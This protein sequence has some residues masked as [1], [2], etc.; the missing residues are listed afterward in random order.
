MLR[1]VPNHFACSSLLACAHSDCRV[2]SERNIFARWNDFQ[3]A[4][5]RASASSVQLTPARAVCNSQVVVS[6]FAGTEIEFEG[7]EKA[8]FIQSDDVLGLLS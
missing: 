4:C 7:G 6:G 1:F 2:T 3:A 5:T 8:K